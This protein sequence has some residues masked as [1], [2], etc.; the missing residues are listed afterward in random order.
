MFFFLVL[1]LISKLELYLLY[2]CFN[3]QNNMITVLNSFLQSDMGGTYLCSAAR[4][5]CSTAF[6]HVAFATTV[7]AGGMTKITNHRMDVHDHV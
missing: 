6:R 3:E 5:S 1:K 2:S 7:R 4:L